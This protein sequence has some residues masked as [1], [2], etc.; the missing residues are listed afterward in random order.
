MMPTPPITMFAKLSL[1]MMHI[2]GAVVV[3]GLLVGLGKD[4]H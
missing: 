4:R 3:V 1:V 2:I